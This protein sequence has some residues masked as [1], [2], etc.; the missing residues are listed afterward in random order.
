M[1]GGKKKIYILTLHGPAEKRKMKA[2][3]CGG[4]GEAGG[5]PRAGGG[6]CGQPG[7]ACRLQGPGGEPAAQPG[8]LGWEHACP[9]S[10][11]P[12]APSS[13]EAD[14][15]G[16]RGAFPQPALQP[17]LPSAPGGDKLFPAP[18]H[19][20]PVSHLRHAPPRCAGPPTSLCLITF[21][22]GAAWIVLMH[23][24]GAIGTTPLAT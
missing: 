11:H 3:R 14:R 18:R 22:V 15:D 6:R 21:R 13:P 10:G 2:G 23:L 5:A 24:F 16:V 7:L 19:S 8:A 1:R 17:L 20:S 12:S 4:V 9:S